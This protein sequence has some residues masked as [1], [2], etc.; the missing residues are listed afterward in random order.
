[1][2]SARRD[3]ASSCWHPAFHSA[4]PVRC[5]HQGLPRPGLQRQKGV[6][7]GAGVCGCVSCCPHRLTFPLS[8]A[9]WQGWHPATGASS[10]APAIVLVRL[11]S[12]PA[13]HAAPRATFHACTQLARMVQQSEDPFLRFDLEAACKVSI[14][15]S[16]LVLCRPELVVQWAAWVAVVHRC[17]PHMK[18]AA[19]LR[20]PLI[21]PP[22]SLAPRNLHH[23]LHPNRWLWWMRSRRARA[24]AR[25]WRSTT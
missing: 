22:C 9:S 14:N 24:P 11:S 8:R 18:R 1:M 2:R 21:P 10:L 12:Q 5:R 17:M 23:A 4:S 15:R 19:P 3:A 25:S 16:C 13:S 6:Q 20:A 7:P